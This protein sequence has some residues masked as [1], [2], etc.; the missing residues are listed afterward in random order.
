MNPAHLEI[1][2]WPEKKEIIAGTIATF[3]IQIRNRTDK[4]IDIFYPTGQRWDYAI[5]HHDTQIYRWS[6]GLE[7]AEAPH[8]VPLRPGKPIKHKMS[9]RSIDRLGRPLPVSRYRFT[10]MVMTKP[11]HL[12][13]NT[14][15][16][17][18]LPPEVKKRKVLTA[19]LNQFFEIELPRYSSYYELKWQIRYEY[20]DNRIAIHNVEKTSD[21][22]IITFKAKR[23]GH[24]NFHF[25]ARRDIQDFGDSIER[26]SY[27]VIVK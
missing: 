6:Q 4:T 12:V 23:K 15:S 11:R 3:T 7:W 17:D 16:I 13:S 19:K 22:T 26:R 2:A 27:R 14:C 25:Y 18:L 1:K 10:G 9:W 24:V 5:F 20:N 21:K 8:S